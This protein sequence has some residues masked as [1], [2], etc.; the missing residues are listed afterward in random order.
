MPS[1]DKQK[2]MWESDYG[3]ITELIRSASGN[4]PNLVWWQSRK[5]EQA[6]RRSLWEKESAFL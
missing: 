6:T 3:S 1:E 5:G 4:N 2:L